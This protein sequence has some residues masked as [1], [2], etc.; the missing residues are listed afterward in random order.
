VDIGI[1]LRCGC[2]LSTESWELQAEVQKADADQIARLFLGVHEVENRLQLGG[3][4]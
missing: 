1:A 2:Y 3:V 4:N